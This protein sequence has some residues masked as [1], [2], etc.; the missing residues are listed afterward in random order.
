MSAYK[1]GMQLRDAV[2]AEVEE[3][4]VADLTF[5]KLRFVVG[6]PADGTAFLIDVLRRLALFDD[7]FEAKESDGKKNQKKDDGKDGNAHSLYPECCQH[8]TEARF[9]MQVLMEDFE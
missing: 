8:G 6:L 5:D 4:V 7:G 2:A 1:L 9:R 3:L